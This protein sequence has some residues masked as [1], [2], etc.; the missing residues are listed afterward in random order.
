M[1][2]KLSDRIFLSDQASTEH[3]SRTTVAVN[4]LRSAGFSR[5]QLDRHESKHIAE[6][7]NPGEHI[8]A[9]IRGHI[10]G[11]GGALLVATNKRLLYLHD[12]PLYSNFEEFS[13]DVVSGVTINR[14]A[15]LSSITAFT[16]FKT[17]QVDYINPRQAERFLSYVE[18]Q[19]YAPGLQKAVRVGQ[20]ALIG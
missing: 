16:K 15:Y 5:F 3:D 11:I 1:L 6:F 4:E 20:E 7:L 10:Y 14:A 18:S 9:G 19:I 13:Y 17:Y 8:Y 12:I 2:H